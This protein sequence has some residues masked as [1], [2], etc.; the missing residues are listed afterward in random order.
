[1]IAIP[2][3]SEGARMEEGQN[4]KEGPGPPSGVRRSTPSEEEEPE[5]QQEEGNHQEQDQQEEH[6]HEHIRT[7]ARKRAGG[8]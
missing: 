6:N 7:I 4:S 2:G 3:N 8:F 1:V 5:H